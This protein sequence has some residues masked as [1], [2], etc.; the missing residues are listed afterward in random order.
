M[1]KKLAII[2]G[3]LSTSAVAV[4]NYIKNGKSYLYIENDHNS[5]E[6]TVDQL[7][8]IALIKADAPN[9]WIMSDGEVW[10]DSIAAD[11]VPS[12][13]DN[14]GIV[15]V[16]IQSNGLSTGTNTAILV[17]NNYSYH[18]NLKSVKKSTTNK[19]IFIEDEASKLKNE[20]IIEESIDFSKVPR[21]D[22]QY[23]F[24]GDTDSDIAPIEV[25]NDGKKTYLKM[26]K[27]IDTRELPSIKSFSPQGRLEEAVCRYKSPFFVCD[28]LYARLSVVLGSPEN[29]DEYALRVNIYRGKKPSGWK[30]LMEQYPN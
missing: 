14:N 10:R 27:D 11:K 9:H 5:V 24:K 26:P 19:Y 3:L 15:H 18:I 20:Q 30:W 28:G 2:F 17:G 1:M 13:K 21:K 7:C 16:I 12:Y 23:Y 8:D 4:N 6:C 25:F 29:S 22:T